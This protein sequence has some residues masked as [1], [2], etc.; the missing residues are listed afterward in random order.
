MFKQNK[1]ATGSGISG[2]SDKLTPLV[3]E[4]NGRHLY[5]GVWEEV[6]LPAKTACH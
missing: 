2:S 1:S 6:K 4:K 5:T 3:S